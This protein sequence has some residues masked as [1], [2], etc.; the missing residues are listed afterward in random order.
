MDTW[1]EHWKF[2]KEDLEKLMPIDWNF[3]S[4]STDNFVMEKTPRSK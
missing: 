4:I 3:K 2:S 1:S